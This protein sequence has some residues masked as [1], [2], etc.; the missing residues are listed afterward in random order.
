[1]ITMFIMIYY[2]NMKFYSS[3]SSKKSLPEINIF[4]SIIT[5]NDNIKQ[6]KYFP[7]KLTKN[8]NYGASALAMLTRATRLKE[9]QKF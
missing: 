5:Q 6:A 4:T 3:L 9:F 1:M 7:S 2:K 8:Q